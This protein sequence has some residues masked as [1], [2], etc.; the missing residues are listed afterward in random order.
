MNDHTDKELL[1]KLKLKMAISNFENTK[2]LNSTLKNNKKE[3]ARN[4]CPKEKWGIFIMKRKVIATVCASFI[5]ISGLVLATN[6]ENIKKDD[7][8]LGDGIGTAIKNGYIAMPNKEFTNIDDVNT[9]VTIEDFL[10]DD[11]NLSIQ[12]LFK[13]DNS[14]KDVV[15]IDNVN[16][17]ELTDL[18]IRDE[19]NRIIYG[20]NNEERFSSY[21]KE[22][23]LNY[24]FG[25]YN[26]N[27]MNCGVNCFNVS[28][29]TQNNMIKIMYNINAQ[30]FPK[31]KKLYFSFKKVAMQEFKG[32]EELQNN[33]IVNGNWEVIVD[34]PEKMYNRTEEY[35]KVVS[36]DNP[37]FDVYTA[38]VT[39][40]GFEIGLIISNIEEPEFDYAK[41]EEYL[42]L[43]DAYN[44]GEI[45]A[46][47]FVKSCT[48]Y[49]EWMYFTQPISISSNKFSLTRESIPSYI[50]N[51]K[52]ERFKCTMSANRISRIN[53]LK[54]NK[55]DFYET[56]SMTKHNSTNRIK[57]VLYYYGEPVNIELQKVDDIS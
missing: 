9:K 2:E 17:I 30:K 34:V 35:Y 39:D 19:Q 44:K 11:V 48:W 22:N 32:T 24:I 12:L 56:F 14:I 18:I 52:G 31:S 36:C 37:D 47:E 3:R 46:E 38:K 8:G 33:I 53:F 40:T 1:E 54:E 7:R 28:H 21:C 26:S 45:S 16:S 50:E 15:N 43:N 27:Y 51:E 57:A 42:L 49:W 13:F 4:S 23:N 29:D 6:I 5:I 55:C 25:D 10:M 41:F 20:G